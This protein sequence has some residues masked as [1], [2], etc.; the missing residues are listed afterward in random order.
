MLKNRSLRL[1]GR[2][3]RRFVAGEVST[4]RSFYLRSFNFLQR[5]L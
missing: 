1:G 4:C 5:L 3:L 2:D